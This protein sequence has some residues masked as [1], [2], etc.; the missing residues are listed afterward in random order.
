M[1]FDTKPSAQAMNQLLAA[2][3]RY[4]GDPAFVLAGGGNT[5]FK[6]AD[7]LWV[8]ASGHALAT[9]GVDGFVE[10][11][12]RALDA[13][14]NGEWPQ[15]AAQR[16][17]LFIERVMAARVRPELGQRPSVEALLH[18]LL[19]GQFVV[20]THPGAV[21][22]LTCCTG[23]ETLAREWFGDDLLWQSYVD[24]GLVLAQ[25]LA[26]SVATHAR[27]T[28]RPAVAILLENH[29]LIVAADEA[30]QIDS[31]SARIVTAVS[32]RLPAS[33][34]GEPGGALQADLLAVY[35]QAVQQMGD[36]HA[37]ADSADPVRWLVS[38]AAGKA[39]ALAGPL[40]PDQIVYCRS[41]PLWIDT[42]A[43]IVGEARQQL[44]TA[45]AAYQDQHGF[46]PW[47]L[48]VEGVGMIAVRASAK[49][50][51]ITRDVYADAAAVYQSA[52]LLG[53]I[54]PLSPRD[55]RFIENWEVESFRRDVAA[56]GS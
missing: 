22:A 33:A 11:D 51:S 37:V 16:E 56:K 26:R 31:I 5:S 54:H 20:H 55:R 41:L 23:G 44:Q 21:N 2:S 4:G 25:H 32:D 49:L 34:K 46:A 19:P 13:M 18:H 3:H 47:V 7:R 6:T 28:G 24:P 53:G 1:E 36:V 15:D 35:K 48:L 12:R 52:R 29:G 39:A 27:R 43:E 9:I 50:A 40:T 10:L 30:A 38:T 8:K 45:W 14:L 17:S 42:P